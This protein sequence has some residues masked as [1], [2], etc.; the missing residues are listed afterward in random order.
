MFLLRK[1]IINFKSIKI[2]KKKRKEIMSFIYFPQNS[3]AMLSNYGFL[4][5]Y[6][7]FIENMIGNYQK[8]YTQLLQWQNFFHS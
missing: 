5:N 7:P 4:Q 3:L 1:N 2:K 8:Q 6:Q